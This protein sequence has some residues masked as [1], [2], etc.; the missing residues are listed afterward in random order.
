VLEIDVTRRYP[1]CAKIN[2]GRATQDAEQKKETL[3]RA[4]VGM[5]SVSMKFVCYTGNEKCVRDFWRLHDDR[6]LGQIAACH[7]I[8]FARDNSPAIQMPKPLA[9]A[10]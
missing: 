1:A 8:K 9:K 5:V 10:G 4:P 2:T 3:H 7:A 6:L